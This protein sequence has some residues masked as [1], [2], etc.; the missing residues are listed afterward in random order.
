MPIE[1]ISTPGAPDANTL[2]SLDRANYY[3]ARRI[4]LPTPWV[5]SGDLPATLLIM[6]TRVLSSLT[7]KRRTLKWDPNGKPYYYQ[8]RYWLGEVTFANQSL[9][10]PR[11]G[12]LTIPE[13]I[14][15]ATAE[16]AGQ[17]QISDRTLDNDISVQGI[18]GI[19]AGPVSLEFKEMIESKALPDA[20][21]NLIPPLYL[22]DEEIDYAIYSLYI[23]AI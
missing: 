11:N 8:S 7:V 17:L 18:T 3:F 10:F 5:T 6:S 14:E 4:P 16:L 15:F 22:S 19:T 2:V 20:V 1:L 21:M 12:E 23:E 13:S 9:P